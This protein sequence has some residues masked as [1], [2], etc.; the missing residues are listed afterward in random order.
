MRDGEAVIVIL[1]GAPGSGKGTQS[2]KLSM[3]L[4][5]PKISTGDIL[6]SYTL[7]NHPLSD[8][9]NSIIASGSLVPDDILFSVISERLSSPDCDRG[10]ILDGYPRN[11]QQA[12][13][14]DSVLS[15]R[16]HRLV[17][18]EIVVPEDVLI[19]RIAGRFSCKSCGTIY[20]QYFS[21]PK[22]AGICDQCGSSE[23]YYRVDDKESVVMERLRAY[24]L[25]TLPLIEFYN[26]R[27]LVCKVNGDK[28]SDEVHEDLL[29]CIFDKTPK[30]S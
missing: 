19:K 16:K 2:R 20:N 8:K 14:L 25:Q 24:Q 15:Q 21:K 18:V 12:T 28:S 22:Q 6:R 7:S 27:N 30:I 10:F 4:S 1:I 11:I 3:S 13:F 23:F 5:M 29:S 26:Q 9:I 17:V